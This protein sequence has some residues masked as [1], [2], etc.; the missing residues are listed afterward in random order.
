MQ[1]S[2]TCIN[3]MQNQLL[4]CLTRILSTSGYNL[5]SGKTILPASL[6]PTIDS[7][8]PDWLLPESLHL[9]AAMFVFYMSTHRKKDG[10]PLIPHHRWLCLSCDIYLIDYGIID[11]T[12]DFR[13]LPLP[14]YFK[15]LLY[16]LNALASV[17]RQYCCVFTH[18][19][20]LSYSSLLF[21]CP[22]LQHVYYSCD[23]PL[24]CLKPPS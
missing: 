1:L 5:Y 14:D 12:T 2:P 23:V 17:F 11:C 13:C 7:Y 20:S 15:P 22:L 19:S 3:T 18:Y 24:F 8:L 10:S 9:I 4:L 21:P 6:P 16:M